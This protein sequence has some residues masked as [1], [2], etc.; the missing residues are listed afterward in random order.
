MLL[1]LGP[2]VYG[3]AVGEATLR[4]GGRRR[5][6]GMEIVAGLGAFAGIVLWRL[7]SLGG[8]EPI[9]RM[10]A[11]LPFSRFLALV[12]DPFDLVALVLGIAFAVIHIRY[13]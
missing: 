4:A 11:T 12:A 5:G 10:L 1:L 9:G 7:W 6:S 13:I 8:P 3:Y 2:A